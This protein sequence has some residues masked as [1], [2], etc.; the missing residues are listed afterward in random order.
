MSTNSTVAFAGVAGLL[1][2]AFSMAAG[3]SVSVAG[4]RDVFAREIRL[5]AQELAEHP[6]EEARELEL[7]YRAKGMDRALAR[8]AAAKILEDPQVADALDSFGSVHVLDTPWVEP[9][10]VSAAILY[11]V[12]DDGR[13]VT[14]TQLSVD[15]GFLV[16]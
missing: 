6:E 7:L 5:E 9:E 8:S 14:G 13:F 15:A 12:S 16:K 4:Q 11:L 2:G 1:A 10:D 3:E